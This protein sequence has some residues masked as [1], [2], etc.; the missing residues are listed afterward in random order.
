MFVS[1][2]KKMYYYYIE[3]MFLQTKNYSQSKKKASGLKCI[4]EMQWNSE[5][6]YSTA[7]GMTNTVLY[8]SAA[9]M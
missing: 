5:K 3:F 2:Y 6:D 7:L 9:H 1:M 8:N 4:Y